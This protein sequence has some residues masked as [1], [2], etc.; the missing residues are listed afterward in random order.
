MIIKLDS[1]ICNEFSENLKLNTFAKKSKKDNFQTVRIYIQNNF[2]EI[3]KN[4]D[5]YLKSI[6]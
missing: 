2:Q 1:K 6:L 3:L 4:G 5:F